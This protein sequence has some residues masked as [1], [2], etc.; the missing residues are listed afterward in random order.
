MASHVPTIG[1]WAPSAAGAAGA[2]EGAAGAGLEGLG[3]GVASAG[4]GAA[5]K[6][7]EGASL[8]PPA[9][10]GILLIASRF[11][12]SISVSPALGAPSGRFFLT[13]WAGFALGAEEDPDPPANFGILLIASRFILSSSDI[14]FASSLFFCISAAPL[15]SALLPCAAPPAAGFLSHVKL[16]FWLPLESSTAASAAGAKLGADALKPE[17]LAFPFPFPF[18]KA[19]AEEEPAP[20][21]FAVCLPLED[22]PKAFEAP[23]PPPPPKPPACF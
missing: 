2:G 10:V 9:T 18:P 7:L 11:S 22:G 16:L 23:G 21:A 4:F 13:T 15:S 19:L 17:S 14:F 3:F 1:A 5:L 12:R 8:D 6:A 20:K